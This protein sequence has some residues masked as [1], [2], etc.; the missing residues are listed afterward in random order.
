[1]A[2]KIF[3]K[4]L[5]EKEIPSSTWNISSAGTWTING[6]NAEKHA[7]KTMKE[8]GLDLYQHKTRIITRQILATQNLILVMETQHKEALQYE[9][10]DMS[11]RVF[12][13]SQM[14]NEEYNIDDPFRKHMR[15]FRNCANQMYGILNHG[16]GSIIHFI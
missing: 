15:A 8:M 5:S 11:D 6:Q 1:M 3:E 7:I 16:I 14:V 12:L 9:F 13:L 2:E 4:I 10:P